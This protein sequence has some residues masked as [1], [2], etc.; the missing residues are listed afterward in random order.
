MN[1]SVTTFNYDVFAQLAGDQDVTA[2]V[3]AGGVLAD[4]YNYMWG[5]F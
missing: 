1:T 3:A 4:M 5:N 2:W